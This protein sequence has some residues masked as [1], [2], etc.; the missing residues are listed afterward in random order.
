VT[1][2]KDDTDFINVVYGGVTSVD[3][4]S[5]MFTSDSVWVVSSETSFTSEITQRNDKPN[6]AK[7]TEPLVRTL[8][9]K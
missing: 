8:W 7:V 4:A 9:I 1:E 3:V 5:T 6:R 2:V